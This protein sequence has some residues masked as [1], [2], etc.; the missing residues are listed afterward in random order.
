MPA[1][2][3]DKTDLNTVMAQLIIGNMERNTSGHNFL[4][5]FWARA[6]FHTWHV[7]V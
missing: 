6:K 4:Y 5:I 3:V 7:H 1:V 2:N